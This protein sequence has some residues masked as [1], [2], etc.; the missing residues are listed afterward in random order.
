MWDL[1][2]ELCDGVERSTEMW[3]CGWRGRRRW[4]TTTAAMKWTASARITPPPLPP[5]PFST[6]KRKTG[7]QNATL[8]R[9]SFPSLRAARNSKTKNV[10]KNRTHQIFRATFFV[11][12]SP[13]ISS[14]SGWVR[15]YRNYSSLRLSLTVKDK[16]K[17][18]ISTIDQRVTQSKWGCARVL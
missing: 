3:T 14:S 11:S 9:M 5:P 6:W 17:V 2:G 4:T 13:P 10:Y 1:H 8:M 18:V 7:E 15:P 12:F 16:N